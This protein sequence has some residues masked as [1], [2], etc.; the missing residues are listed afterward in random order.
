[1]EF[2]ILET[3][4]GFKKILPITSE[5]TYKRYGKITL[6]KELKYNKWYDLNYTIT[7]LKDLKEDLKED[8]TKNEKT[9]KKYK[10]K[11]D[12]RKLQFFRIRKLTPDLLLDVYTAKYKKQINYINHSSL[13]YLTLFA[14]EN[15]LIFDNIKGLA[16]FSYLYQN[17]KVTIYRKDK[18]YQTDVL[19]FFQ[20]KQV[21][22]LEEN[23]KCGLIYDTVIV[24]GE[25]DY[26]KIIEQYKCNIGCLII[27]YIYLREDAVEIFENLLNDQD[28][29]DVSMCDFF[30]REW[31]V[32]ENIRPEMRKDIG[33]G[34]VVRGT[35]VYN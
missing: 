8:T 24:A 35:R 19:K 4:C 11:K 23:E 13:A 18:S 2:V 33:S 32:E 34:F 20:N 7:N 29:V 12:S 27:F 14:E 30:Y 31:Q 9:L 3:F 6:K 28:F 10:K 5:Y 16:V 1:M 22:Y 17:D 21:T 25:F 15:S 26:L